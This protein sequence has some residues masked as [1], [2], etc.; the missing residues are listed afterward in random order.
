MN[1]KIIWCNQVH[2]GEKAS[3][4]FTWPGENEAGIC[5][6]HVD[7]LI[8][9]AAALGFPLRVIPLGDTIVLE[10]GK[11]YNWVG[12][13]ERLVYLGRHRSWHQFALVGTTDVWCEVL[14]SDMHMLEETKDPKPYAHEEES[15]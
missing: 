13:K 8:N 10:K 15:E 7:K 14:E 11:R 12:Q 3:H 6:E 2:C 4:R 1:N 9:T 5:K